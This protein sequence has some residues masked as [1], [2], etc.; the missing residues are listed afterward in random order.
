MGR[1]TREV[2]G[3]NAI[4]VVRQTIRPRILGK[5]REKLEMIEGQET[6][7]KRDD[8]DNPRRKRS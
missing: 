4:Q 6:S 2:H 7:K 8:K 5:I 1:I 3:E